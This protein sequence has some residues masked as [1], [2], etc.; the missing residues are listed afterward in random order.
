MQLLFNLGFHDLLLN[1]QLDPYLLLYLVP[2]AGTTG[3]WYQL[4][5]GDG[6]MVW[7]VL[8]VPG[9]LACSSNNNNNLHHGEV[10]FQSC[11]GFIRWGFLPPY[12]GGNYRLAILP[13]PVLPIPS[14]P[15]LYGQDKT[16]SWN[17]DNRGYNTRLLRKHNRIYISSSM[18]GLRRR[19]YTHKTSQALT[20]ARTTDE[21]TSQA[22]LFKVPRS[23]S[24][25][26]SFT[27]R[28]T[29]RSAMVGSI[30]LMDLWP[31]I[32][33]LLM[34]AWVSIRRRIPQPHTQVA[35]S[36]MPWGFKRT[37]LRHS[38]RWFEGPRC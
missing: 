5:C 18:K 28:S 4:L 33:M 25:Q 26:C 38:N 29:Y 30:T 10:P 12:L 22:R 34:W 35:S 20:D 15:A 32:M 37:S 36:S 14:S 11:N 8:I 16:Y 27:R 7:H 23:G 2:S 13:I 9:P 6:V 24:L 1:P 17:S 19:K 31:K 3:T 21:M